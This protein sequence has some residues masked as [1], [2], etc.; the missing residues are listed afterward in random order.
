MIE[1]LHK[2]GVDSAVSAFG[3]NVSPQYFIGVGTLRTTILRSEPA[4]IK[5]IRPLQF[6]SRLRPPPHDHPSCTSHYLRIQG[7]QLTDFHHN[8]TFQT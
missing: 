7:S 1:L 4:I 3:C 8:P 6:Y 5:Q 2:L